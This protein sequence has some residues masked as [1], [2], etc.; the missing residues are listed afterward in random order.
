M[1]LTASTVVLLPDGLSLL[2]PV[3]PGAG[4]IDGLTVVLEN[5]MVPFSSAVESTAVLHVPGVVD[6]FATLGY[7]WG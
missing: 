2:T 7:L 6:V 4:A 1:W 3:S 5:G